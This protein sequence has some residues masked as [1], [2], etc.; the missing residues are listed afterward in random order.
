MNW[1]IFQLYF[2]SEQ[3][4]ANTFNELL[5]IIA[6]NVSV[7]QNILCEYCTRVVTL[8]CGSRLLYDSF[9]YRSIRQTFLKFLNFPPENM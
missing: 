6:F 1:L 3:L 8:E 9:H 7:H 5:I 4:L 2:T